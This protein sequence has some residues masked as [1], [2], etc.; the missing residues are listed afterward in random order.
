MRQ[1]KRVIP[2]VLTVLLCAASGKA[3]PVTYE[4]GGE[5]LFSIAFPE[6]WF[7]D[8]D[9]V[10]DARAAGTYKGGEPSLR[11]LEAMPG[12]GTK[13]WFG[14][15][16][17]PEKVTDLDKA[18]DYVSSLDS[19]LFT[20]VEFSRPQDTTLG[21]MPARTFHGLAR[22]LGEPVEFAV[23]LFA[24]REDVVTVA[25]YVGRPQTWVKHQG[26]L[27]AVV[28]SIAPASR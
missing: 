12:D 10:A 19:Q 17:A 15:W 5:P 26:V 20:Q 7:V 21:G 8:N 9:F 23:A 18:F 14:I 1:V 6:G 24:P 28:E 4:H 16:V 25:L 22:R 2:A 3:E 11:I 13:L 27:D